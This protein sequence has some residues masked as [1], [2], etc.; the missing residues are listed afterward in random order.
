MR[1]KMRFSPYYIPVI[2]GLAFTIPSIGALAQVAV[3][4]GISVPFAPPPLPVYVQ[5]P[6]PEVGYMWTPGSWAY[7]EAGG[8][9][10]V[11]GTW[12]QP[13]SLGVLWTPPY[14]GFAGG[15]YGFHA[16]YWGAHVG[17]Y[18][19][20]NYGFGYVGVGFGGGRWVGNSFAYNRAVTNV[21]V[22]VIHNSYQETVVNNVT[23][24][25]VSYNG[26]PG[27]ISHTPTAQE[28]SFAAEPHVPPTQLQRQHFQESARNPAL[29]A[30]A[31]GGHPSIAATPRAA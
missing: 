19:G 28:R 1:F 10:W 18:G 30:R 5:P 29:A 31:N 7:E 2:L 26:G 20:V 11:P 3:G 9:Y 21:N 4:V 8:Y 24:N 6:M 13:P 27:G 25:K 15:V 16:G 23:V 22:T 14:W 12:V 17:F